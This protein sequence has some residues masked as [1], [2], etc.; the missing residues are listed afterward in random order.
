MF[1]EDVCGFITNVLNARTQFKHNEYG[2]ICMRMTD[3]DILNL[4]DNL[5]I[6]N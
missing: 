2:Q 1:I 3:V 6:Q 5:V 4:T